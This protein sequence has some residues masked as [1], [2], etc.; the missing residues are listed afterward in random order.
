VNKFKEELTMSNNLQS[1]FGDSQQAG[2]SHQAID[3]M[4]QNLDGQTG[5]GCVGA[6][7]DDLNSDD[8]TLVVMIIDESGSMDG[9]RSAVLDAFN[10][11][12]RALNDSKAAD[13]ILMSA[14]TFSGSPKLL[15]GYTPINAVKDLTEKEYKPDGGTALYDAVLDGFTGIVAY[16]QDL[17]NNGIRTRAIIVVISDGGDNVSQHTAH[18]VK[19][20]ADDLM[21]QEFYTLA[22]IGMGDTATFEQIANSMG[23]YEVLTINNSASEI[24]KALNMVSASIIRT[25]T[26]QIN[27][28]QNNFFTP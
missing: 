14:W 17:R 3:L 8:V 2:M 1:L 21:K 12:T 7:I 13:S 25:S 4:V 15:F 11:M 23:F 20:V 18:S 16:G 9:V 22:Y 24:R 6:Q 19:T 27:A 10:Q 5:L 28:G 26:G